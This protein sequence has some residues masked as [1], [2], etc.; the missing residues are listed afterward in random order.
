[1]LNSDDLQFHGI[2]NIPATALP[3][4]IF[5]NSDLIRFALLQ[6]VPVKRQKLQMSTRRVVPAHE[7]IILIMKTS[8]QMMKLKTA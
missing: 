2:A 8:K 6:K 1:M 7:R 3:S 5:L 4:F